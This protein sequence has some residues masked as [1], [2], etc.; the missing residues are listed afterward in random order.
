MLLVNARIGVSHIHG[1]GLF[2]QQ[3]I[4][5]GTCVWRFQPGFDLMIDETE[6]AALSATAQAQVRHYAFYDSERRCYVLSGDDD[7]FT[8]HADE[9]NT[10]EAGG[11]DS[12]ASR[13]IQA[14]EEITWSYR[15][16]GGLD[17]L[18]SEGGGL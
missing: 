1:F 9:P 3:F 7:R 8:N 2:A 13:D 17:F 18:S 14:G 10:H 12:I 5:K 11:Y 6:L 16:W 4:S 15:G